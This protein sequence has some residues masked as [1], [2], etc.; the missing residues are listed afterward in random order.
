[1]ELTCK[2]AEGAHCGSGLSLLSISSENDL[3]PSIYSSCC[4]IHSVNRMAA[5]EKNTFPAVGAQE[6]SA[7][8]TAPLGEG[9]VP[10]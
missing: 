2:A 9:V 7:P 6:I 3:F 8:R 5:N 4:G 10:G 1:M